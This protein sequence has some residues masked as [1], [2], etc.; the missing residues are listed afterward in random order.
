MAWAGQEVGDQKWASRRRSSFQGD[1]CRGELGEDG[2]SMGFP[3]FTKEGRVLWCG[4]WSVHHCS[5]QPYNA[6]WSLK[7]TQDHREARTPPFRSFHLDPPGETR[8]LAGW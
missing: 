2:V 6:R 1:L 4:R 7:K 8:T 3:V 5:P